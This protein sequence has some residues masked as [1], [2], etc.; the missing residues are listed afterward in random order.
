[1]PFDLLVDAVQEYAIF[2]LDPD[3][4]VASWNRGAARIKGYTAAE[5]LGRPLSTFYTAEDV[6][7]GEPQ[8]LLRA[9][10]SMGTP[11]PRAGACARTGRGSGPRSS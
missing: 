4:R 3:G 11:K 9:A 8:R 1:M 6:A 2:M 5:V 10:P 7:A